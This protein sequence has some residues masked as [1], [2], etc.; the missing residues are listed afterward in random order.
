MSRVI[1]CDDS[2]REVWLKARQEY[3]TASEIG[4]LVGA[5]KWSTPEEVKAGK[6]GPVKEFDTPAMWHGRMSEEHNADVFCYAIG[7]R[8]RP[9]HLM[10][11]TGRVSCTLDGLVIPVPGTEIHKHY[12]RRTGRAAMGDWM[13]G[14]KDEMLE[15]YEKHGECGILEMKTTGDFYAKEWQEGIPL[16]YQWQVQTQLYATGKQWGV[17]ACKI[18]NNNARAYTFEVDD[19]MYEVIGETA[20]QFWKDIESGH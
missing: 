10:V 13:E 11:A 4:T 16:Y 3:L 18:S 17:I 19:H 7:A 12:S 1:V 2:D 15:L 8:W 9:C 14:V 5:S 6:L 20:T